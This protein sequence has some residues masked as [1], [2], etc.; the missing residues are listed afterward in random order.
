MRF[1]GKKSYRHDLRTLH[2]SKYLAVA[3]LPPIPSVVDYTAK[4]PCWGMDANDSVGDC[5]CAGMDHAEKVWNANAGNPFTS[6]EAD[7]LAAY[8]AITGYNPAD[9]STDNGAELIDCLKYWMNIGFMGHKITAYVKVDVT[10]LEMM[11]TSLYLFEVLY[12]GVN[13]PWSAQN[14]P[15]WTVTDTTLKGDAAP[16]S[17]GG[18]CVPLVKCDQGGWTCVTWGELMPMNNAFLTTYFDEAWAVLTSD[19]LNK[20]SQMNPA[21]FNLAGLMADLKL[22][23]GS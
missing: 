23:Q 5:T 16:G 3:A 20:V 7:V 10:N 22:V 8:T 14:Q 9:P 21:G 2:L 13:L 1:L 18:H 17:W 4:V 12:A 11:K 15:V 6:T 19:S